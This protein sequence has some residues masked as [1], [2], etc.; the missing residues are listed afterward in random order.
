MGVPVPPTEGNLA[1]RAFSAQ[2]RTPA[3]QR[4]GAGL[5]RDDRILADE[6]QRARLGDRVAHIGHARDHAPV[7]LHDVELVVTPQLWSAPTLTEAKTSPAAGLVVQAM[8]T[9]VTSAMST[10]PLPFVTAQTWAGLVGW[11]KTVTL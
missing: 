5:Q 6:H 4:L 7:A 8:A 1:R 3:T 9:V 11:A 10:L 2:G